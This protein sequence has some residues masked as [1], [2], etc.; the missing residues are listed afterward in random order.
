EEVEI[1]KKRWQKKNNDGVLMVTHT[2]F[3]LILKYAITIHKSQGLTIPRLEI[4]CNKVFQSEQLY[5]ALSRAVNPECLRVLNF[6]VSKLKA[7]EKVINFMDEKFG[8]NDII[9]ELRRLENDSRVDVY[10]I[11]NLPKDIKYGI[12]II[13]KQNNKEMKIIVRAIK[14][15]V[16]EK[17]LN[18]LMFV[19][20]ERYGTRW[21]QK[22]F[23][24]YE[25]GK[26]IK[27]KSQIKKNILFIPFSRMISS[28]RSLKRNF[29]R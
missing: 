23:I 3:S 29:L 19:L 10:Q 22:I 14:G 4:D 1:K 7:N 16:S 26:L 17:H 18:S 24:I 20:G 8:D 11:Y 2:Q 13:K 5:V 21:G 27:I 6:K 28:L 12:I 9:Y 15:D 25:D